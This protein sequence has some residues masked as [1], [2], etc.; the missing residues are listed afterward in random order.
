M[1]Q[2]IDKNL[3]DHEYQRL[4][5]KNRTEILSNNIT[6]AMHQDNRNQKEA[7][8]CINLGMIKKYENGLYI[9]ISKINVY[10]EF[11]INIISYTGMKK[12]KSN[13]TENSSFSMSS[14][15][16][17]NYLFHQIP[18]N[19]SSSDSN[20]SFNEIRKIDINSLPDN[21][22][23]RDQNKFSTD[24]EQILVDKNQNN[25]SQMVSINEVITNYSNDNSKN[26]ALNK[27]EKD[28]EI[29]KSKKGI[30]N[31]SKVKKSKNKSKTIKNSNSNIDELTTMAS[32]NLFNTNNLNNN[33]SE[34]LDI[35]PY[36]YS[37]RIKSD[38]LSCIPIYSMINNK[39]HHFYHMNSFIYAPNYY[40]T[41]MI[42]FSN[43]YVVN[44]NVISES[45]KSIIKNLNHQIINEKTHDSTN[46]KNNNKTYINNTLTNNKSTK[47]SKI[48]SEKIFSEK[49]I[50]EASEKLKELEN[51]INTRK[52]LFEQNEKNEKEDN[53]SMILIV[54]N[55]YIEFLKDKIVILASFKESSKILQRIINKCSDDVKENIYNEVFNTNFTNKSEDF[56]YFLQKLL[57]TIDL[58]YKKKFL[59]LMRNDSKNLSDFNNKCCIKEY[60]YLLISCLSINNDLI[61][62]SEFQNFKSTLSNTFKDISTFQSMFKN[63]IGTKIISKLYNILG[64]TQEFSIIISNL[65]TEIIY[66]FDF[67]KDF[68]LKFINFIFLNYNESFDKLYEAFVKNL[69]LFIKNDDY[70]FIIKNLFKVSLY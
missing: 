2:E 67:L 18:L 42:N 50:V 14:P 17:N 54:K 35:S 43:N 70:V 1:K 57:K 55:D 8:S 38:N 65:I 56:N 32:L 12:E 23:R 21:E 20:F 61:E 66:Q 69:Q 58:K 52:I 37:D 25:K 15:D 6:K 9:E 62:S 59:L 24:S 7:K 39:S 36:N 10:N 63:D 16:I 29:K 49:E 5:I 31:K 33:Y 45:D 11:E 22:V 28:I 41:N 19:S 4:N 27:I 53:Y 68:Q 47:K 48:E 51:I 30:E 44:N 40:S 60:A 26:T 3:L 34:N 46:L 64:K 13:N